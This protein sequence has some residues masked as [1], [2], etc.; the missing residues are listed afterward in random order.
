[1]KTFLTPLEVLPIEPWNE[2]VIILGRF[3]KIGLFEEL[4]FIALLIS[5][6]LK[7]LLQ[8][9][10]PTINI[11]TFVL[12]VINRANKLSKSALFLA[13]PFSNSIFLAMNFC[14]LFGRSKKF[15]YF[16]SYLLKI[17]FKIS[18]NS[19]LISFS[20]IRK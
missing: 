17:G 11:G 5:C 6:T 10:L 3:L 8:P 4:P 1:M 12:I 19:S 16:L 15:S 7:D 20:G 9:G 18:I 14:S 2:L 13:I